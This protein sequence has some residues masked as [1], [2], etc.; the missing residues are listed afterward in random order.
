MTTQTKT[1]PKPQPKAPAPIV[2]DRQIQMI[3]EAIILNGLISKGYNSQGAL[4]KSRWY[5]EMIVNAD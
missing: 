2:S 1:P 3:L 5:A 4:E